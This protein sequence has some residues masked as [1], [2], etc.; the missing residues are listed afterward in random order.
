VR[1]VR[2]RWLRLF[3]HIARAGP[4]MDY[5]HALHAAINNPPLNWKRRRGRP[6]NHWTRTVEAHLKSSNIV[7]TCVALRAEPKCMEQTCADNYAPVWGPLLMYSNRESSCAIS[8]C[9]IICAVKWSSVQFPSAIVV[10][11]DRT[12]ISQCITYTISKIVIFTQ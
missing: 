10:F 1:I 11:E 4:E 3:D 7:F 2:F 8:I 12:C 5:S 9:A 6:A